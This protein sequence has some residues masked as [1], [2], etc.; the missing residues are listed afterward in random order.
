MRTVI[1]HQQNESQKPS[2]GAHT[3]KHVTTSQQLI[4]AEREA[5][6]HC[7]ALTQ[8]KESLS[9]IVEKLI[10]QISTL[11]VEL[12]NKDKQ[13]CAKRSELEENNT[14]WIDTVRTLKQEVIE[15][16]DKLRAVQDQY[17]MLHEDLLI[18]HMVSNVYFVE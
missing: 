17:N 9:D 1:Q 6:L 15:G 12:D 11:S 18:P 10:S 2:S 7:F 14:Q 3:E 13:L 5:N 16:E 8:E 4:D